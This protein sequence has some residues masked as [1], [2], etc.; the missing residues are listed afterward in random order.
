MPTIGG[1]C[2]DDI[3]CSGRCRRRIT[4]CHATRTVV[5]GMAGREG[6]SPSTEE[7]GAVWP[8]L[9]QPLLLQA[10]LGL[11]RRQAVCAIL[12]GDAGEPGGNGCRIGLQPFLCGHFRILAIVQDL[13]HD[14]VFH[15]QREDEIFDEGAD[16]RALLQVAGPDVGVDGRAAE[17]R[18]EDVV[19]AGQI[20][21]LVGGVHRVRRPAEEDD[22]L[23]FL[24]GAGDLREHALLGGLD[25]FEALQAESVLVD[26]V[27]DQAV[28]VIARLDA[29]DLAVEIALMG[30]D[31]LEVLD[32]ERGTLF[33]GGERIL[34]AFEIGA[35]GFDRFVFRE[36]L[37][38]L[39]HGG[40]PV[41]EEDVDVLVLKRLIGHRHSKHLDVGVVAERLQEDG[42]R[43][44]SGGDVGPTHIGEMYG[45]TARRLGCG[46][47][48]G[49]QCQS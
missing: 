34:G 32:A 26:H 48:G 13:A 20:G 6:S 2:S 33:I 11:D 1:G 17:I 37:D 19:A 3:V 24:V 41:A 27:D 16:I 28:A 4:V 36:R 49:A 30:G 9:N 22:R 42:G 21:H 23:A 39:G 14:F 45:A 40:H 38:V 18:S 44:G 10:K 47:S 15:R 25:H 29:I 7:K 8:P 43:C 12:G 35:D 46:S 5:L 31:I